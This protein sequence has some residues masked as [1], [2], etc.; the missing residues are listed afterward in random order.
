[1]RQIGRGISDEA[2][3]W[4]QQILSQYRQ[5]LSQYRQILSQ[6]RMYPNVSDYPIRAGK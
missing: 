5:I 3:A 6:Y 2:I 1:L 4:I